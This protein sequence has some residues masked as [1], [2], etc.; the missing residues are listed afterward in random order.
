M[1]R[2]SWLLAAV[3]ATAAWSQTGQITGPLL[4]YVHDGQARRVRPIYGIPSAGVIAAPVNGEEIREAASGPGIAVAL[5]GESRK[6]VVISSSGL[7]PIAGASD[8]AARVLV[9]PDGS[10]AALVFETQRRVEH[11]D[12]GDLSVRSLPLSAVR[13][14]L[15]S[16]AVTKTG[17]VF[18]EAGVPG[19]HVQSRTG[20]LRLI[21]T[22]S[23][24]TALAATI[25][26]ILSVSGSDLLVFEEFVLTRTLR[27]PQANATDVA[28]SREAAVVA[29]RGTG[30]TAV[31]PF[32]GAAPAVLECDCRIAG[33][34]P[35]ADPRA[36]RLNE[37]GDRTVQMVDLSS[38]EAKTSFLSRAEGEAQ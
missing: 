6:A 4:G 8:G 17:I 20:E 18:S 16:L 27:V 3:C 38:G 34:Y 1:M 12:L 5:Q 9:S 33:L 32:S 31:V 36:W 11:V 35:T 25:K 21:P 10:A 28:F 23:P 22:V 29:W 15:S 13:G 7:R 26:R 37:Y 24:V 2:R 14:S 19:I 30:R